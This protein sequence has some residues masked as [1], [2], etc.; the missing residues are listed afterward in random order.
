VIVEP[1]GTLAPPVV[2]V[3][4]VHQPGE[5]FDQVLAGLATQDYTNLK[6][7]VLVVGE[8]DDLPDRI[9][10]ALPKAFV[11]AVEG[12][13]GFGPAANDV[14]RLV[15][16]ENGFFCFL[17]DDV[18]LEPDT[19]RLL[20]EELYRSNAGIVGPKL[21][22]WDRPGVLQHVGFAVDRFGETDPIVEP[23][24]TDQEQHDAVRDVFA[25]PT[26]CLL[27][28]AD[29][30]RSLGGFDDEISYHGEDVDLC[31]RAHHSGA[32][33]VVV[34]SA[35]VRHLETLPARRPDL[36]HEMLR[37]RH[38]M[39]AV[40]TL[41]GARRL[42]MLSIELTL[43]T[44]AQFVICLFSGQAA[45]GWAGVRSLVGLI[46]RTPRLLAR[47]RALSARRL[48]PDREVVGLQL[49]GSARVAAHMRARDARPDATWSGGSKAW[50]ERSGASAAI[51]WC[52]LLIAVVVG[53]RQ[54]ITGG[55]PQFGQFLPFDDSPRHMLNSYT[56]GWNPQG[57]GRE[58]ASPTGLALIALT[59]TL[60]LFNMGLLHTLGVVGAI[61][62]G[63]A[64]MWRVSA[65][66][67]I[68]R[69]RLVCTV[70]YAAV[71]LCNQ[72]ISMGRWS[73]LAVSAALPWSIDITRRAAGLE[74]G[75]VDDVG[76]RTADVGLRRLIQLVAAGGLVAAVATAFAP[77]YL[78]VVVLV[79]VVLGLA[80]L[81]TGASL[82]ASLRLTLAGLLAAVVGA[83]LNLPWI[84]SLTVDGGWSA[85]VGPAPVG[86]RGFSVLELA[87]FDIGNA[88]GVILSLAL[89]VPV[90]G[91]VLVGRGWR[92]G[93]AVRAGVLVVVFGWL[94][95]LDDSSSLPIRLP[96]PGI[97]LVP[98]AVGLAIAAGCVVAS[99]ELDVRG[100]SFGW[101]QPLSLVSIIAITIGVI[102]AAIGL[103]SG[104]WDSPKTTL[105][106][107]LGVR[108][109]DQ[110]TDGD[111]RVLWVGDQRVLP[112]SGQTYRPG[113][114]YAVTSDRRLE[115]ADT[116]AA[117]P[118]RAHDQIVTALDAIATGSTTRAGRLLAPYAIR[119]IIVPVV[120]GAS[121]RDDDPL[122][123]PAGLLDALGDQLDLAEQH[124]PPRFI[125]Y[126]NR[127]WIPA[128][129]V[130]TPAGADAS[131]TAGA[132]ALAQADVSGATP[133]MADT[134]Q[135]QTGRAQVPAGTL[136]VAVP[137][138]RGW[139]LEVDGREVPGRPAFGSTLAFDVPAGGNATLWYRTASSVRL[140]LLAQL[141]GWVA[142]GLAASHI[143]FRRPRER[144]RA[145]DEVIGPVFTLDP[146]IALPT[147][148]PATLLT[149]QSATIEHEPDETAP[150]ETAP[151][152]TDH[153]HQPEPEP[154]LEP[155]PGLEIVADISLDE[156]SPGGAE[157]QA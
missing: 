54:L 115:V 126:E 111:Y 20:V 39:R 127:A 149:D 29:L 90:V 67:S 102:P 31:W 7:L 157:V 46:P 114:G 133:I 113:I 122:P 14:L 8:A 37:A 139:H 146:F 59:S 116:W 83:L 131:T 62:V 60:T 132:E 1:A 18:A 49:R 147:A 27:V 45:R 151:E 104:R 71:P 143:R 137:F 112:V 5:W 33:V 106:D 134:D 51:G 53:G 25:L 125:V 82:G 95:A 107:L 41:S 22:E 2:A 145:A 48:V 13:P 42:P 144:W 103:T 153:E 32:R 77:A 52:C 9:R 109:P 152:E 17:H 89:Y 154:E 138:D 75:P 120:D 99:F 74:P 10:A 96:E 30:F 50:R 156:P 88:R 11:R 57:V 97:M 4:V 6:I 28:R 69:S 148:E 58:A 63:A 110:P 38:R 101:R 123:V 118:G 117:P 100:G 43:V 121:S 68:T 34:P 24:E 135:L 78:L 119:F 91:A 155:A 92:F 128:R 79:A 80:T 44:L 87:S 16:G 47:R 124:S 19:I 140:M 3:M 141:L 55:V 136:H 35:R 21:V 142:V 108:L 85:I 73:A 84:A 72:M 26:A 86:D 61:V 70:V 12:N 64:G 76:E 130:L 98:V 40:A 93:W 94:A 23:G 129:S 150:D 15:E 65:A 36:P 56:S 105:I 66:F 81:M